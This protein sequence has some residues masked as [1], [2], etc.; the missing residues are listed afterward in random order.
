MKNSEALEICTDAVRIWVAVGIDGK[1]N[2]EKGIRMAVLSGLLG[3]GTDAS[4]ENMIARIETANPAD[5][6]FGFPW[7][8]VRQKARTPTH[9]QDTTLVPGRRSYGSGNGSAGDPRTIALAVDDLHV[10]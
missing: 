8:T 5:T 7:H 6:G 4:D 1:A 3:T 2:M 9:P 10:L